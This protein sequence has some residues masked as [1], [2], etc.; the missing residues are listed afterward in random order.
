MATILAKKYTESDSLTDITAA[1]LK[2]ATDKHGRRGRV[3]G[4][5]A[6]GD[7][8]TDEGCEEKVERYA[9]AFA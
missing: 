8:T 4:S 3:E 5:E 6:Q 7:S 2:L 9:V 1:I